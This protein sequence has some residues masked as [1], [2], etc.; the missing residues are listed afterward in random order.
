MAPVRAGDILDFSK[1]E[2]GTLTLEQ[3]RFD[4]KPVNPD[5]LFTKISRYL[6]PTT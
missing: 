4:R 3:R 6:S 2:S 5:V 1:I